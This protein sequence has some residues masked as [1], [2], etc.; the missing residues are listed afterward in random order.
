[1]QIQQVNR[2]DDEKVYLVVNNVNATTAT[3][4]FG[5][6]WVG[7]DAA[8]VVSTGGGQAVFSTDAT[9]A[10]FA[11]IA[12]QDIAVNA[13]G[14]VIAYG[15]ASVAYSAVANATIGVGGIANA[16]LKGGGVAGTFVSGGV[17]QASSVAMFKYV[18]VVATTNISGGQPIGSGFVR[19][20]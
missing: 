15:L 4:G 1:M 8:E 12:A 19:G 11:G 9:M 13:Y 3:T 10:Q 14:R 16:I 18:Y 6:R 17:P 20:L 2:T 5:M 7:G